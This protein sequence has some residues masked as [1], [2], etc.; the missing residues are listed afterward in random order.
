METQRAQ[1]KAPTHPGALL[2]EIVLPELEITPAELAEYLGL[3]CDAISEMIQERKSINPDVALR[4][5][6]FL[7]NGAR[8]WLNMQQTYDLW[9]LEKSRRSEYQKIQQWVVAFQ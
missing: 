1:T 7:G 4:L 3:S 8:L 2:R 9:Q 6:Q 5:G